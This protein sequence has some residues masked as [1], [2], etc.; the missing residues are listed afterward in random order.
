MCVERPK[1]ARWSCTIGFGGEVEGDLVGGEDCGE[2]SWRGVD[3]RLGASKNAETDVWT[4]AGL[5][6][7]GV[8]GLFMTCISLAGPDVM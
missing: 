7:G 1:L 2:A 8:L 3:E 4:A 6:V 5:F